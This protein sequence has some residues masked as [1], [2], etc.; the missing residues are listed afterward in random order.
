MPSLCQPLRGLLL[1]LSL[2]LKELKCLGIVSLC[3]SVFQS[4]IE[5]KVFLMV[6][7]PSVSPS[8]LSVR[9]L[10]F[11]WGLL[12][13]PHAKSL[14]ISSSSLHRHC[15]G[16]GWDCCLSPCSRGRGLGW[17]ISLRSRLSPVISSQ[18]MSLWVG[19]FSRCSLCIPL[20]LGASTTE[21]KGARQSTQSI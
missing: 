3:F 5:G 12:R 6:S 18:N 17:R 10:V 11:R 21:A 8:T 14:L 20:L 19:L 9:E 1:A 4:S 7:P 16:P 13:P 2:S 15:G